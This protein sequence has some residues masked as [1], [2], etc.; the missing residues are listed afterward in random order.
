MHQS[1]C[2]QAG[3]RCLVLS[4]A[5]ELALCCGG[6]P[7]SPDCEFLKDQLTLAAGN[8]F[9]AAAVVQV[10]PLGVRVLE[11]TRH[12]QV[13]T[14][15][16]FTPTSPSLMERCMHACIFVVGGVGLTAC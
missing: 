2:I 1:G 7:C 6:L 10:H 9:H 11:G 13:G 14:C 15:E 5:F 16:G 8:L 4:N 3:R 12:V